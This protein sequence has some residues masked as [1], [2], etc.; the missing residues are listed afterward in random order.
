M[1]K[2][3]NKEREL[4]FIGKRRELGGAVV[5]RVPWR[6]LEASHWS[7]C[8]RLRSAG[9]SGW[10]EVSFFLLDSK[11]ACSF[12]SGCRCLSL[13][14]W[15]CLAGKE[16]S[17]TRLLH[18]NFSWGFFHSFCSSNGKPGPSS[19]LAH[20]CEC[21][22]LCWRA[23][24]WVRFP[25]STGWAAFCTPLVTR[26]TAEGSREVDSPWGNSPERGQQL[27]LTAEGGVWSSKQPRNSATISG[28]AQPASTTRSGY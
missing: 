15:P 2:S 11:V 5:T 1:S 9:Q 21:A 17:P 13:P 4:A 26:S 7:G 16:S 19:T 28:R 10:R 6:K 20:T 18:S 22:R 27:T 12:L 24:S 8:C 14:V 3:I 23:F 25:S